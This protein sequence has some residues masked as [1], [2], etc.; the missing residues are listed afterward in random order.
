MEGRLGLAEAEAL[1]F[2]DATFDACW[3]V[4]GFNY[5]ADHEA[6]LREMRRVT[7]PGGTVVVA[8]EIPNLHRF[9]IGHL[10][11]LKA[12]DAWWL[13]ALGLDR[14][15]VD[16]VLNLQFD[17]DAVFRATWPGSVRYPIWFGLGY[18][19]VDR[20]PRVGVDPAAR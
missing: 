9:G 2:A 20:N 5:F 18:C 6:A 8:D 10:I 14:E 4:G 1:P 12:I 16:M 13:R 7:R 17:P 3:T 11:G 15:F 19:F